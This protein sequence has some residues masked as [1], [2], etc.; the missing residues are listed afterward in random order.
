[1]LFEL[2]AMLS[3]SASLGVVAEVPV[4]PARSEIVAVQPLSASA[5]AL[6]PMPYLGPDPASLSGPGGLALEPT[7]PVT[8][9]VLL[10]SRGMSLLSRL[11]VL[12]EGRLQQTLAAHPELAAELLA[13]PPAPA[14][15]AAWWTDTPL[16]SRLALLD[17]A[18]ELVGNLEG[19]PYAM[20]DL[21]NRQLLD[22]TLAELADE[23]SRGEG[24]AAIDRATTSRAM[25]E[26]VRDA[27]VAKPGEARR[28]L[29]ALDVSEEGRAVVASGHVSTADHVTFLVP[30]MFFGVES[31]IVDWADT[32]QEL[33]DEQRAWLDRLDRGDERVAAIAWIGYDT[34]TLLNVADMEAARSG[35]D[36]VTAAIRGLDASRV[37]DE[38]SVAIVAHSYGSAAAMLALQ[39]N[40]IHVDALAIVGS[41]GSP[42]ATAADL[43][44]AAGQ[45]YAGAAPWDPIPWSGAFGSQPLDAAYGARVMSV[46]GGTDPITGEELQGAVGHNDYFGAGSEAMRNFALIGI[47]EGELVTRG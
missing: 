8:D 5:A 34:P 10:E 28:S 16:A 39:E 26:Q 41:P 7:G 23:T 44:V 45:V 31:R 15:V 1:M 40:G 19:V 32:A 22:D 38:P 2:A 13:A 17:A 37:G 27:L 20:R 24:R 12:P 3:T 30:G 25:L 18:P 21:A 11:A 46:A 35:R 47:G 43:H 4:V 33:V 42:A 9:T 14:R 36:A 29:L 6:N